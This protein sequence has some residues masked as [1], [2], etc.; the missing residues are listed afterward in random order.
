MLSKYVGS[1]ATAKAPS[2]PAKN[3]T[4]LNSEIQKL[5]SKAG[6]PNEVINYVAST[7]VKDLGVKNGKQQTYIAIT[8]KYGQNEGLAIY[9]HVKKYI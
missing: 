8:S 3:K 7:A 1:T 6:Y 2:V 4:E 9:N 5:L